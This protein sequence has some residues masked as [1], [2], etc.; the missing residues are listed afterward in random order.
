MCGQTGEIVA[1]R[2]TKT[3]INKMDLRALD[4]RKG[5]FPVTIIGYR[6]NLC[7]ITTTSLSSCVLIFPLYDGR[8]YVFDSVEHVAGMYEGLCETL[9]WYIT[10][11]YVLCCNFMKSMGKCLCPHT[12]TITILYSVGQ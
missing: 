12:Y 7:N 11:I 5:R 4:G 8:G 1:D 10:Y 9:F 2:P 3:P 6:S